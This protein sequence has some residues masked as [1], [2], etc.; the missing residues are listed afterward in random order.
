[1]RQA[2]GRGQHVAGRR[3]ADQGCRRGRGRRSDRS[4][5]RG[6][7]SQ[8]VHAR[9][10]RRAGGRRVGGQSPAQEG[11]SQSGAAPERLRPRRAIW[12][13]GRRRAALALG[14]GLP[15]A[16]TPDHDSYGDFPDTDGNYSPSQERAEE[17]R[18]KAL[19]LCPETNVVHGSPRQTRGRSELQLPTWGRSVGGPQNPASGFRALSGCLLKPSSLGGP[20]IP[21]TP[22]QA[23]RAGLHHPRTSAEKAPHLRR[24]A[25]GPGNKGGSQRPS[26]GVSTEGRWP[27]KRR[28][29]GQNLQV[30]SSRETQT[31]FLLNFHNLPA[32]PQGLTIQQAPKPRPQRTQAKGSWS[33]VQ[34]SK[35][36]VLTQKIER[37]LCVGQSQ[38][39]A[40]PLFRPLQ[41]RP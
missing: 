9:G 12:S 23:P 24:K 10:R 2:G 14:S 8:G 29:V 37:N 1:M 38:G 25:S 34:L 30:R 13:L 35:S 40:L 6:A 41:K 20:F 16:A 4:S 19:F 32:V 28:A 11:A 36:Q 3:V 33:H 27:G 22:P 31:G 21:K 39:N 17:G 26:Q 18:R 7:E 5:S 15:R